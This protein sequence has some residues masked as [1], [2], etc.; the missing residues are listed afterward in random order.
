M[1]VLADHGVDTEKFGKF[2]P[3]TDPKKADAYD[4]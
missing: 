3:T 4:A 1:Q 2:A